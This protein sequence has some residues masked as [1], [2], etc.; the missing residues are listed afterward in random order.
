M[1][2]ANKDT[3]N[4]FGK[5]IKVPEMII[6]FTFL[7][8]GLAMI[9]VYD[10]IL[11]NALWIKFGFVAISIP[12]AVVATKK[13]NK[14][15]MLAGVLCVFMA[16]GFAEM[17]RAGVKKGTIR[18]TE[19]TA[20]PTRDLTEIELKG[21]AI[22]EKNCTNCHG[23]SGDSQRSGAARLSET[24]LNQEGIEKVIREGKGFMPKYDK[25]LISQEDLQALS[26]YVLTLKK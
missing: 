24:S 17:H 26:N 21:Q 14:F 13:Q 11:S 20:A 19:E 16:Y 3:F 15:L 18:A 25:N 10:S 12:L 2:F 1:I 6:S 4:K 5:I 8:T 7:A 9:F 22:Y 23:P